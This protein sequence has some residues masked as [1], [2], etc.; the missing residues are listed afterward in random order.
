MDPRVEGSTIARL[1]QAFITRKGE[2][3]LIKTLDE[4]TC[5]GLMHMYLT[6]QPRG[7]FQGLPPLTDAACAKWVRYMIQSGINLVALSFGEGVVGHC[8]LFPIDEQVCE[9][10]VVVHPPFQNVGIGT[11]L[12][13]CSV[14]LAYE[15]GFERIWLPV[16]A[17]NVRA[18]HVYKKC[19]FEYLPGGDERE[20]EMALNLKRYHD[21][22]STSVAEIMNPDVIVI[23]GDQPCRAAL[24][25][26]LGKRVASLPVI[27]S[28]GE[29]TGI[30]SE[31]DLMLPAN[32]D[33]LVSDIQTRDVLT[34]RE[35]CAIAKVIRLFESKKIRCIPVVDSN[36]KLVGV[37]G[38]KDVLAYYAKHL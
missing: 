26:F 6:F 22:L 4:K 8:A 2:A 12:T 23:R 25:L 20:L 27:D 7:S 13:R 24:E 19:G 32:I 17:T 18:R 30:I 9:T 37:V 31:T 33:R 21:I 29:L 3:V 28:Q 38:R 34:V 11:Q 14:Q 36:E 35:G 16:E 5:P 10:L 1:P 15:I